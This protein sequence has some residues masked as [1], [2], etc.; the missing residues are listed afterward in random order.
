MNEP[1]L[2][3][4]SPGPA[5]PARLTVEFYEEPD[6]LVV[7]KKRGG[8][9]SVFLLLWL[10]GWTVACVVLLIHV[11][12]NPSVGMFA[13]AVPFWASWLVG[14]GWLVWV[15]F[16][17]ETLLLR[18]D[19]AFF[20]RTALIRLAS[21]VVPWEEIQ[22]FREC[23]SDHTENDAYLWGIEMVTL[24]K[25]VRF[26]FRL[27]DRERAWLMHQLNRFL[28][29]FV[30]GEVQPV[31]QP[32]VTIAP[33]AAAGAIAVASKTL[34][35]TETL[36]R[37]R[38]LA[39]PPSDCCWQ[40]AE[41]ADAFLF[42]QKGCLSIGALAVLLFFNAFWNGIVSGFVMALFGLM[43]LDNPPQGWEWWG[44]FVF[45][46]PFEVIGLALLV[47]LVLVVLEPC[48]RTVWRFEWDRIV[49]QTRWPVY[50]HT[51]TF[52]V[53]DLDRLELRRRSG[54]ASRH[55][56]R[57]E[58]ATDMTG[59]MQFELALVAGSNVDLCGI[60]NLTEGEARWMAGIIL[61]RRANWLGT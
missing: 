23:R 31:L 8:G 50:R 12:K 40:L 36:T 34:I 25:P 2:P 56:G 22:G 51:R 61:D 29:T 32:A 27:P 44:M 4:A 1:V 24:G 7:H 18:R 53:L 58:M 55:Q 20:Q 52:D 59:P 17:K 47:A 48:R 26:A 19:E 38:T 14:A 43:P 41:D 13:F 45:L 3:G 11:L 35:A 57:S 30:P 33:R 49:S 9:P 16:G 6:A 5:R 28:G 60:G 46:I 37:E 15:L 39:E 54:T 21:R 10:T 42:W